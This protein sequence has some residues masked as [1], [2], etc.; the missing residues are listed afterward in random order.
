MSLVDEFADFIGAVPYR[1]VALPWGPAHVWDLG[2]G[3]PVVLLH[4]ISSSRRVFFRLAPRLAERFRVIVPPLRGEDLPLRRLTWEEHA[5]DLAALLDGMGLADV[6]LFGFSFGG[7][8]ALAYGA[9]RDPRIRRILVQGAFARFRL[10][11]LDRAFFALTRLLPGGLGSRY[12]VHRVRRGTEHRLIGAAAEGLDVLHA[13]WCGKT[14]FATLRARTRLIGTPWL[15]ERLGAVDVP[16]TL[17]RGS[18]DKVVPRA[19]FESLAA[20]L[21]RAERV[22]W[23]D[24]GHVAALTHPGEVAGLF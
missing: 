8:A 4:G 17:A 12:F 15:E 19:F 11:P 6:T 5:D 1:E 7:A 24:V 2:K 23:P 14:P 20:R 13:D 10:R 16:V 9:R 21:P 22:T 3:E 18:M